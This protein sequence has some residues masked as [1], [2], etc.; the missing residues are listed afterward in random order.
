MALRAPRRCGNGGATE[1]CEK[2]SLSCLN[3]GLRRPTSHAQNALFLPP[4]APPVPAPPRRPL[5][6][7]P[8]AF[9]KTTGD[10]CAPGDAF[11][12]SARIAGVEPSQQSESTRSLQRLLRHCLCHDSCE[13]WQRARTCDMLQAFRGYR[14]GHCRRPGV[15]PAAQ[16]TGRSHGGPRSERATSTTRLKS[17]YENG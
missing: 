1:H 6:H 14:I 3:V 17:I 12:D 8:W 4:P 16:R 2:E 10:M 11:N 7:G 9:P 13:Q 15:K 5:E